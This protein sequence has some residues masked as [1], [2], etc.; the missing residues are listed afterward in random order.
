MLG[1]SRDQI[2]PRSCSRDQIG[3]PEGFI[4]HENRSGGDNRHQKGN[5]GD[6]AAGER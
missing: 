5:R 2:R 1:C 3:L 4:R 6:V